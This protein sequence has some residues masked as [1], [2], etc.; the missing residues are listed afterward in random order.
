MTPQEALNAIHQHIT[1]G[2][3]RCVA[4]AGLD[5][6]ACLYRNDRGNRCFIGKL[7][8]DDLYKPEME[9]LDAATLADGYA[10]VPFANLSRKFLSDLQALHDQDE[11]WNR[12]GSFKMS[13]LRKI[14][15]RYGL[16]MPQCD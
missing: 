13:A 1:S 4:E 12:D 3:S 9:G 16:E 15:N 7:I 11:N 10:K 6:K 8:P 5:P 14:A 2:A